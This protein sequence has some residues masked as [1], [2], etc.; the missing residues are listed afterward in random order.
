[1]PTAPQRTCIGCHQVKAR[2]DLIRIA[3]PPSGETIVIDLQGKENGRGAYVC[4]NINC[5]NSAIQMGKLN[6]AFRLAP[7][8]VDKVRLE[9]IK[10]KQKLLELVVSNQL[11][12][13]LGA[14]RSRGGCP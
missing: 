6:R 10:L 14:D 8:S 1:M 9:I 5:I 13:K 2:K 7:D 3:K 4:P 11:T 12:Q